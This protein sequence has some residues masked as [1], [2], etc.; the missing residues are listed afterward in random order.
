MG[1][2]L[3]RLNLVLTSILARYFTLSSVCRYGALESIVQQRFCVSRS[4][5]PEWNAERDFIW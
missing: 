3:M 2:A 4:E 1:S 5:W